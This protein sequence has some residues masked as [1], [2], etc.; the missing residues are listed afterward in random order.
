MDMTTKAMRVKARRFDLQ[1]TS[2]D[3]VEAL[4]ISGLTSSPED[5]V[6][7]FDALALIAKLC[8]AEPVE[9]QEVSSP[10]P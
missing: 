10:A 7:D 3:L 5:P 4:D 1:H 9:V 6:L 8:G 2:H